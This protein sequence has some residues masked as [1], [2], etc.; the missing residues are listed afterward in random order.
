V[1]VASTFRR[2]RARRRVVADSPAVESTAGSSCSAEEATDRR[3]AR[4]LLDQVLDEM[5]DDCRVVFVLYELEEVTM[6]EIALLLEL[7]PGTVASRLRRARTDF[8]AR[9]QRLRARRGAA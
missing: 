1:R 3:R 6:A 4:D 9:V 8:H 7:P 5:D 2:A